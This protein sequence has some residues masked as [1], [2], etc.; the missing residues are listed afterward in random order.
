M[1]RR[2]SS[3]RWAVMLGAFALG[4]IT[5]FATTAAA[6]Q[7]R[8]TAAAGTGVETQS[9]AQATK[10]KNFNNNGQIAINDS[11]TPPTV[12]TPYPSTIKVG[13]FKKGKI[14]DVNVTL[15]GFG[16]QFSDDADVLLVS[17]KGQNAVVMSDVGGN[18]LVG[19]AT[20]KLDDESPSLLPDATADGAPV[21]GTFKPANYVDF[22]ADVFPAPAPAPGGGS[23]LS[24]F[25]GKNPKGGWKLFV[26]DDASGG[27]GQFA[28]GWSLQ[29]K[30][31]VRR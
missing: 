25:D 30:A 22:G 15:K 20:L 19:N 2:G 12:A 6:Q 14:K 5:L 17:P 9:R 28:G 16:H 11:F 29:I 21:S 23:A 4:L 24:I 13:G 27:T 31:K 10:T 26:T 7:E 8:T 1:E 18:N 3:S